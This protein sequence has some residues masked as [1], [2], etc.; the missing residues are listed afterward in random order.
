MHQVLPKP[1]LSFQ[2]SKDSL[3][4]SV[5]N[6]FRVQDWAAP[7]GQTIITNDEPTAPTPYHE[8]VGCLQWL[9]ECIRPD[10]SDTASMLARYSNNPTEA[11]WEMALRATSYL[12]K[13]RKRGLELGGRHQSPLE[14]WVDAD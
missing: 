10:I 6:F 5:S 2:Q 4:S 11:H 13:T 9:A 14:G 12:A 7:I 8:I 1:S 3:S